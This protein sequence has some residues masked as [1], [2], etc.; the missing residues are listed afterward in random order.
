MKKFF[1]SRPIEILNEKYDRLAILLFGMIWVLY[2]YSPHLATA[3]FKPDLFSVSSA[4]KFIWIPGTVLTLFYLVFPNVLKLDSIGKIVVFGLVGILGYLLHFTLK[5]FGII[6]FSWFGFYYGNIGIVLLI[7]TMQRRMLGLKE[8]AEKNLENY[9][10]DVITELKSE[11]S[12][13][14][15]KFVQVYLALAAIR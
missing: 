5:G 10:K 12:F 1:T 2:S 13:F 4:F 6:D 7:R 3:L 8:K 14:L 15:S 9:D 11:W